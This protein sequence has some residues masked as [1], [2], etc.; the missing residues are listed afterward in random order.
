MQDNAQV[1]LNDTLNMHIFDFFSIYTVASLQD[2]HIYTYSI[3]PEMSSYLIIW[4]YGLNDLIIYGI[5][6]Y[7]WFQ[8]YKL[9]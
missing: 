2:I 7:N 1:K 9:S 4:L 6:C 8:H 5:L 3:K